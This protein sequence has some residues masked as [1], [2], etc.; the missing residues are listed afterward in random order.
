MLSENL[1]KRFFEKSVGK[2][3]KVVLESGPDLITRSVVAT[4]DNYIP[5]RVKTEM[6]PLT[7]K[8]FHVILEKIVGGEVLG[9]YI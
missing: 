8:V 6:S 7:G 9:I 3:F 4:T 1:R 2:T 5:V